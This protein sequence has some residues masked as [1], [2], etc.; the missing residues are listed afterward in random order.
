[1]SDWRDDRVRSALEGRNPTVFAELGAAFAVIGDAQFLPGYSLAL[2]KV[3]GVDR[4]TDLPRGERVRFLADVDLVATAVEAV[5]AARDP[6]YRRTNVEILGN[7]HHFLHAHIWPRYDWEPAEI[8]GNP[9]W[10]Y[11]DGRWDD[12]ATALGRQHE[13]L[14]AALTAEV[15]RL[16]TS[17]EYG[18]DI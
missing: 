16:R 9:V 13:G 3:P 1:M 18:D 7:T 2:T 10:V 8:V 6:Q 4:L 11:P 12:P 15:A 17:A 5:C 14:R